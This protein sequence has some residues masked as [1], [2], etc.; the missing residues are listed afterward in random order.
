MRSAHL[1]QCIKF[2]LFSL[3]APEAAPAPPQPL[4]VKVTVQEELEMVNGKAVVVK[5]QTKQVRGRERKRSGGE[6]KREEERRE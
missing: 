2:L 5:Q 1:P 4:K 6:L 3:K